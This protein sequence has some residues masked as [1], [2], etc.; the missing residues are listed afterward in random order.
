MRNRAL[1]NPTFP[2]HPLVIYRPGHGI[3]EPNLAQFPRNANEFYALRNPETNWHRL[4]L[5]Y[6]ADFYD[7]RLRSAGSSS[8]VDSSSDDDKD[9]IILGHPDLVVERLEDVLGLNEDK[10]KNCKER[11]A[12]LALR[13]PSQPIKRSQ[14]RFPKAGPFMANDDRDSSHASPMP[15]TK[16]RNFTILLAP[17]VR[18]ACLQK[19][20][21]I[22]GLEWRTRSTPS[23]QRERIRL[24]PEDV[25][26]IPRL[27]EPEGKSRKSA[28][29]DSEPD[30]TDADNQTH[31]FTE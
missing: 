25:V 15:M 18:R 5:T 22:P 21:L 29:L 9:E 24:C 26:V 2:I 20:S 3:L 4:M 14:I 17:K 16:S 11:A 19:A 1:K 27:S 31:A 28:S 8:D 23:S 7:V 10:I 13:A 12:L 30:A 6:L